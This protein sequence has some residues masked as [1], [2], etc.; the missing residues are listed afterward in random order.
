MYAE[1]R[2][3]MA[4]HSATKISIPPQEILDRLFNDAAG[5]H[6]LRCGLRNL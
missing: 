3:K 6:H 1:R 5:L 2:G 4:K